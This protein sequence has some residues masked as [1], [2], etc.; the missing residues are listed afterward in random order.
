MRENIGLVDYNVNMKLYQP[1]ADVFVTGR[2]SEGK[3][4]L[5]VQFLLKPEVRPEVRNGVL[6]IRVILKN[7]DINI[8]K[9]LLENYS[10]EDRRI[11]YK[12]NNFQDSEK[13]LLG[14]LFS[15][16]HADFVEV[17][18]ISYRYRNVLPSRNHASLSFLDG[19]GVECPVEV[20]KKSHVEVSFLI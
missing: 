16:P 19:L 12:V 3:Y 13:I 7:N 10:L 1:I 6:I 5:E 11:T 15:T 14:V 20:I 8:L 17:V 2:H 4:K 9:S 18:K